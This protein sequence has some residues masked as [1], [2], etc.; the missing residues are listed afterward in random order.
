MSPLHLLLRLHSRLREQSQ[1]CHLLVGQQGLLPSNRSASATSTDGIVE[2]GVQP[3]DSTRG[4]PTKLVW[5][6]YIGK[7]CCF[8]LQS[9]TS[10]LFLLCRLPTLLFEISTMWKSKFLGTKY[11]SL[12]RRTK[13]MLLASPMV[14]AYHVFPSVSRPLA[15]ASKPSNNHSCLVSTQPDMSSGD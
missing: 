15:M 10:C 8:I 3:Y 1:P 9:L 12:D 11:D 7:Q 13:F 5:K 14:P 6:S 2:N 4:L